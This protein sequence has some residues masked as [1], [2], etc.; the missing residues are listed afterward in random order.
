M[1]R[2][3][4]DVDGVLADFTSAWI[5][6]YMKCG[7]NRITESDV[8]DWDFDA[9]VPRASSLREYIRSY[10]HAPGFATQL[11]PYPGAIKAVKRIMQV[12]HVAFVTSPLS[13][14]T[15]A[16]DRAEWLRNHFGDCTIVSTSE[17]HWVAGDLLID[18]RAD[19]VLKW[20]EHWPNG[21]GIV[22]ERP[23]NAEYQLRQT[24]DWASRLYRTNDWA[25]VLEAVTG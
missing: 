15:W 3:L 25:D 11:A 8:T 20:L 7:G 4:L 16:H 6:A 10:T 23:W 2:V 13:S 21:E 9:C 19:N 1:K 12:A 14:R 17:K 22:W 5:E 18:D 24:T